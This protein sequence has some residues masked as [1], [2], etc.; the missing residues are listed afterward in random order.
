VIETSRPE[1]I[2]VGR[3][4]RPHGVHGEVR[5]TPDSDNPERFA[6]GSVLYGRP[7]RT[8]VAGLAEQQ[9]LQLTVE[10]IRG[11]DAF[12]IVTFAGVA[13]RDRAEALGGYVLE[14]RSCELPD[15]PDGEFYPFDLRGLEARNP[16][17]T[18][19]GRV[20]DVVESPAHAI[21]IIM[22][23]TGGEIMV[24]FVEPAVPTVDVAAGFI[25]VDPGFLDA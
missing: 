7:G 11:D 25:V 17:G 5:I 22:S 13:D 9:Q 8:G 2:E 16:D 20:L 10:S 1:W 21:I 19:I 23:L 6:P 24:P 4:S 3:V 15:L 18:A 14:V 12:P